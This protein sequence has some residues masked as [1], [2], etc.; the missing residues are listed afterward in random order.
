MVVSHKMAGL[1]AAVSSVLFTSVHGHMIMKTPV[2]YSTDSLNN[3]P[4]SADGS[5]FPC[6]L[7]SNAF[8]VV[9]ENKMAIGE[10]QT[11][12]FTGS[13]VHGGGSC[14]LSLTKD[15]EPTADS[16]FEVIH[17]IEGGCPS[18]VSGNLDADPNGSGA[19]TFEFSIPDGIATGEYTLAWTW[20]NKV[21]NREMYMNCAPVTV[22]SGSS[23]RDNIKAPISKIRATSFPSMFVANI[24][25]VSNGCATTEGVDTVFPNPGSSVDKEDSSLNPN[26]GPPTGCTD[27]SSS[28]GSSDSSSADSS[29]A[30]VASTSAAS[31]SAGV[32]ATGTASAAAVS[33]TSATASSPAATASAVSSGVSP[34][35][36]TSSASSSTST[37]SSSSGSSQSGACSDEG[38]Y[39]CANDGSSFQRCASGQWSASIQMAT[40][41]SCTP[42]T[43]D[44][45]TTN[46]TKL[47]R[48]VRHGHVRKSSHAWGI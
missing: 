29:T 1:L 42:G 43:S 26:F 35:S 9:T 33:V 32:F 19:A 31:A 38:A 7:R 25:G 28:S 16:S 45:L 6:K 12:S 48:E 2:P 21:G 15:R 13:A 3:S 40:G 37:S 36:N 8:D 44:T 5:D 30:T 10:S 34:A 14:Q 17:S 11:L 18:N 41:T 39:A 20:F 46:A 4:L 22:S 23:K 47:K 27:S 24:E